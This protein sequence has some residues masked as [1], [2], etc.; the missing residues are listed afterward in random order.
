MFQNFYK[1]RNETTLKTKQKNE[2]TPD[3]KL[4]GIFIFRK[5]STLPGDEKQK[6][7]H[8]PV[9]KNKLRIPLFNLDW[10]LLLRKY[11]AQKVSV[12]TPRQ[13][14]ELFSVGV[15]SRDHIRKPVKRFLLTKNCTK[16]RKSV[17]MK[18]PEDNVFKKLFS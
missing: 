7:K 3:R 5:K 9:T 6:K 17:L 11:T 15:I 1:W 8:P 12:L 14:S 13:M 10:C 18:R 4:G 2:K 16:N